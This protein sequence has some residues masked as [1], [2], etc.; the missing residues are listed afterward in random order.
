MSKINLRL[1]VVVSAV[2]TAFI[3][4]ALAF[5]LDEQWMQ[6]LFALNGIGFLTLTYLWVKP[7]AALRRWSVGLH[8][9]LIAFSALTIVGYFAVNGITKIFA[10]PLGLFT[11][12]A[13]VVLIAALWRHG[14]P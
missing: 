12:L 4:L 14:K 13:E 10:D 2:I 6:V 9:A 5:L 11:K 3:H 1:T 8:Y 7:P